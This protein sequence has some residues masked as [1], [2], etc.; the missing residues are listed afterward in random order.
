M[1]GSVLSVDFK[2]EYS[3]WWDNCT[4]DF[5][6]EWCFDWALGESREER[7]RDE[8]DEVLRGRKRINGSFGESGKIRF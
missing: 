4:R 6:N 5:M 3:D 8:E 1:K 2:W 7:L